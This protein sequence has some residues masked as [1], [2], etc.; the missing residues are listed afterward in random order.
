MSKRPRSEA[1]DGSMSSINIDEAFQRKK[2]K[3]SATIVSDEQN[4][5]DDWYDSSRL[6]KA[7]RT[8]ENIRKLKGETDEAFAKRKEDEIAKWRKRKELDCVSNFATTGKWH[9]D[10]D[11]LERRWTR[12]HRQNSDLVKRTGDL[13]L[14][15]AG[16]GTFQ[17]YPGDK[18]ISLIYHKYWLSG[19]KQ[20]FLDK[21]YDKYAEEGYIPEKKLW[22]IFR[23]LVSELVPKDEAWDGIPEYIVASPHT[24][25]QVGK[26]MFNILTR[27]RFWDDDFNTLNPVDND[28]KFGEFKVKVLQKVYSRNLIKYILGC[29]SAAE[30]AR[31]ARQTLLDHFEKVLSVYEGKY[32]SEP[33]DDSADMPYEPKIKNPLIPDGL[34]NAEGGV[35]EKLIKVVKRRHKQGS[36]AQPTPHIFAITDLAKDYDDLTAVLCLKELKRLGVVTLEG[37]VANLMPADKRALFGRGALDSLGLQDIPIAIGTKGSQ[38]PHEVLGYEFDGIDEFM[39]PE[40]KLNDIPDGQVLLKEMFEKAIKEG[41]KLTYLAI[42][43]L[44]DIAEFCQTED[45]A[46]LLKKGL[47]YVVLQ[48][49]YRMV[50]GVLT[51]DP[52]AANNGF[53]I[54]GAQVFHTFMQ[55]NNIPSAVWTKVATFATAVPT[56]VF[57]FMEETGHP[58]GPYLRKVQI[59][60]D[61][62][63]YLR[64]CSDK[65][66]APHMTQSWYLKNRSAWLSSGHE[67]DEPYP[68]VDELVPFFI[69]IIA[70]DA[71][72]AIGSAGDDVVE[73]F[74][75]VKPLTSRPDA[76]DP[77]HKVIGVAPVKEPPLPTDCNFNSAPMNLVITALL[78]G[79]LLSVQQGMQS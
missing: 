31:F 53:D 77:L 61:S 19:D 11:K 6:S 2:Q 40:E 18:E 8:G 15:E 1:S 34:T 71:L 66:F 32:V 60:Q 23:C 44:M 69:N 26:C 14:G 79:A 28:E 73:E 76:F 78:K 45:G 55:E 63:F 29:L 30:E 67:P 9:Y 21:I 74:K 25:W 50:D 10:E 49:G 36:K 64:S 57:E 22:E 20:G 43:S 62:S 39:P 42:S 70:Y 16:G 5:M 58:L 72:A 4:K 38:K 37:F 46:E 51:A 35:Y 3:T 7:Q 17:T 68:T 12:R 48:G 56:T 47:G 59:G 54:E 41:R 24:I 65:P 33:E 52:E 13:T 27:G 75:L